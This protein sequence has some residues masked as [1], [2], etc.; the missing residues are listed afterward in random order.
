M[1][2]LR[3]LDKIVFRLA[4]E[5]LDDV[6]LGESAPDAFAPNVFRYDFSVDTTQNLKA[7]LAAP[8]MSLSAD[9]QANDR[10][11][12]GCDLHIQAR[13]QVQVNPLGLAN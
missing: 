6:V 8:S 11:T 7:Y 13:F 5:G 1:Q 4:A 3:F 10:P 12:L 2:D 9:A